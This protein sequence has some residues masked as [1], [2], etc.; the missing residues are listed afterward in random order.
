M[1]IDPHMKRPVENNSF[2]KSIANSRGWGSPDIFS[3]RG[4]VIVAIIPIVF[5]S[6]I[7]STV[8]TVLYII[9]DKK[10][11]TLS[12]DIIGSIAVVVGL[13][14]GFRTNNAY[15][16]YYEGRRLFGIRNVSRLTWT[17]IKEIQNPHDHNEKIATVKMLLA[18]V[19][20]VKHHLRLEFGTEWSDLE[21]LLPVKFQKTIFD[22]NAG[23][24]N[25]DLG[26][27]GEEDPNRRDL[28]PNETI[29]YNRVNYRDPDASMSLPLEIVF[30]LDAYYD[31]QV[32][33]DNKEKKISGATYGS[34]S[35]SLNTLIDLF[36]NL[37]RISNTPIP[38]AYRIHLKQVVTI[39]VW[40]LPFTLVETLLWLTIPIVMLIAFILF[41]VEAIGSEIENPFGYDK[42]DLPL[43]EYCRDLEAEIQYVQK[44]FPSN[45]K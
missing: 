30:Y 4:S 18:F 13:L 36:G 44:Y 21:D 14:L 45:V 32:L 2:L 19:V 3:V 37:E 38:F 23:Q 10:N 6:T 25:T 43:D 7:I 33:D 35:G 31:R 34:V 15:D 28:P 20:A 5:F 16:R 24:E 17:G 40:V 1:P 41:G 22:G 39:Y 26:A 12:N 29:I 11:I 42:N 9:F 8:V 27:G